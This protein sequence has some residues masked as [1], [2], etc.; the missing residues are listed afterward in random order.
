MKHCPWLLTAD[1]IASMPGKVKTHF[2]N[3]NAVRLN[4]SLGDAVGLR[5]IGVHRVT[6]A[7]G[8]E[9]TEY[10][11]HWHEE[12]CVYILAGSGTARIDGERYAVGEGDFIGLPAGQAAHAIVNDGPENLELLVMGQRLE[13]DVA[14]YPD[15]GKRIYRH[16]DGWDLVDH[17]AIEAITPTLPKAGED[18]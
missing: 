3:P 11:M 9:A 10:H 15:R 16:A 1:A 18:K 12:E 5:H 7:P 8:R 14:D 17:G 4:R 2:L 6:V 13:Q